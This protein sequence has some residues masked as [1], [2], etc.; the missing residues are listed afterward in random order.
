MQGQAIKPA[1]HLRP[2]DELQVER[3]YLNAHYR[4]RAM[5]EQ[6]VGAKL[7]STYLEDL[8]SDEARDKARLLE[9]QN[10]PL[11]AQ[12]SGNGRPTK[13]DRREREQW[14]EQEGNLPDPEELERLWKKAIR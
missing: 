2:G 9:E 11:S 13:K 6:R 14:P 8:T 7:V 1:R 10:R 3:G 12:T 4:V 5:L